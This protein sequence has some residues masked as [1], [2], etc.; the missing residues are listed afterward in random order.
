M[1]AFTP[2][3]ALRPTP[4]AWARRIRFRHLEVLLVIARHG[5]LTAAAAALDVTQPAVSQWLADIESAIGAKLFL[6]GQRLTPTPFAAPLIAHAERVLND[7]QRVVDDTAAIRAG[8]LGHVR[9][10]AMP[11]ATA[12]LV[13][14]AVLRLHAEAP[15]LQLSLV[16]DVA[17]GLWERFERNELD[18][19]VTRLDAHALG[20]GLPQRRL[21]ADRHRLVCGPRHPLLKR[22]RIGWPDVARYPWL[23][24]AAGTPLRQ[25][26]EATFVAESVALPK[27]LLVSVSVTANQVLLRETEALG[28]LSTTSAARA[29]KLGLLRALPLALTQDIGDVGLV[30]RDPVPGP[31]LARVLQALGNEG[32]A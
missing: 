4:P 23:M 9:I 7:A 29:E 6:R 15:G 8:G 20:A 3:S 12:A 1:P 5:S 11:V 22:R 30:W 32:A 10:G 16:E 27:V 31:A 13:P 26:I 14:A 25:A 18:V 17:A 21:F 2:D 24:P 19:L 28:V